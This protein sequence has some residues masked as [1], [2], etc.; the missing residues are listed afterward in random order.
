MMNTASG[1]MTANWL[2]GGQE[3]V[4]LAA[5]RQPVSRR[6]RFLNVSNGPLAGIHSA[7]QVASLYAVLNADVPRVV[8]AID[9][10]RPARL[11]NIGQRAQRNLLPGRRAHQQIADLLRALPELRLHAHHQVEELFALHYLRG[12][13]PAYRRLHHRLHVSHVDPVARD[14]PA[15]HVM[16]KVGCPSWR[17][18]VSSV[19][20]GTWLSRCLT[21][22]AVLCS[23]FRSG[24]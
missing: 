15:V 17:T 24:P 11:L 1:P 2:F 18:T 20:P 14:L 10:R 7:L 5:P 4:V 8:F 21:T 3:L 13:L 23:T 12:R 19:N 6:Q 9:E 22:S 16:V